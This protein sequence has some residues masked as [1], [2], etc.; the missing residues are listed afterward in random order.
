[1]PSGEG[2]AFRLVGPRI[3]IRAMGAGGDDHTGSPL[4][5]ISILSDAPHAQRCPA[6]G[7]GRA[8][9]I[10]A[11][12]S[13]E[14]TLRK[15]LT[16]AGSAGRCRRRAGATGLRFFD[17]STM[18]KIEVKDRSREYRNKRRTCQLLSKAGAVDFRSTWPV[19][20]RNITTSTSWECGHWRVI[21]RLRISPSVGGS[22]QVHAIARPSARAL[23]ASDVM[24]CAANSG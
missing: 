11:P 18:S 5:A 16:R 24:Q 6:G 17:L 15:R 20:L 12:D 22:M 23:F 2:A 14:Q 8:W 19:R 13:A 7:D 4:W 10:Q 1:M 3:G 9:G 21:R